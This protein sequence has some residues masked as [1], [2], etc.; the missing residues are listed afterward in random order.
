[1]T[2]T[3]ALDEAQKCGDQLLVQTL[4]DLR[5]PAKA[6]KQV[7]DLRRTLVQVGD[8]QPYLPAKE[9]ICAALRFILQTLIS[10]WEGALS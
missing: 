4:I 5:G 7:A 2:D 3:P 8:F 10:L 9:R 6:E 1:M